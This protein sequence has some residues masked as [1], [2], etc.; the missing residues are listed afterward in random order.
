[1]LEIATFVEGATVAT[2]HRARR[3]R[4]PD[5]FLRFPREDASTTRINLSP[6]GWIATATP[7]NRHDRVDPSSGSRRADE[8]RRGRTELIWLYTHARC[9][10][11][12]AVW[13]PVSAPP[14]TADL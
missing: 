9:G 2:L 12:F 6:V 8:R 3:K 7:S 10:A 14:P 1:M 5:D 4:S 11:V 13:A